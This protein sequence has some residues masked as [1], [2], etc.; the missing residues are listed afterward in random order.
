MVNVSALPFPNR[1]STTQKMDRNDKL[2][3]LALFAA[4][5]E[6][7][8]RR[9]VKTVAKFIFAS[10]LPVWGLDLSRMAGWANM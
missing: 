7:T 9:M 8:E 6:A 1:E 10:R 2:T 3:C 4:K 5:A